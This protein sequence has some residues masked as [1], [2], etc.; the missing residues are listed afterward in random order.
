MNKQIKQFNPKIK[1]QWRKDTTIKI[2]TFLEVTENPKGCF[3]N[4]KK[5]INVEIKNKEWTASTSFVYTDK[6][7]KDLL[8]FIKKNCYL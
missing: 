5:L 8:N 7:K 4:K 3:T 6:G 1:E 2:K